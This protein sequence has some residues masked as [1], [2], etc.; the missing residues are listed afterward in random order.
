MPTTDRRTLLKGMT[1]GAGAAVLQPA[2]NALGAEASG[3]PMPR[4]IVFF[5]EGNGMNPA[6]IQPQGIARPKK[7]SEK[8][9]DKSLSDYKL[10]DPLAALAPFKDRTTLIQGLSHKIASGRGHSPEYGTL[11]CYSGSLGPA[12]SDDRRGA[13]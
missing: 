12:E 8:L 11:G 10:P 7:G 4:R 6:H 3:K 5:I 9:I 1:L 13:G 2:I